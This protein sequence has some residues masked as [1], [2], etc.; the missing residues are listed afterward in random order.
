[1]TKLLTCFLFFIF[2]S[3]LLQASESASNFTIKNGFK[4]NDLV[5]FVKKYPE[6]K[7]LK[8]A[9]GINYEVPKNQDESY[10]EIKLFTEKSNEAYVVTKF[11]N[12]INIEKVNVDF[13]VEIKNYEGIIRNT[14]YDSV[15][16]EI[17][18]SAKS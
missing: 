1:M 4:Q 15:M 11:G 17:N 9:S 7:T 3:F 13:N 6:L 5:T 16:N 12:E 2:Y 10:L 8:L 18:F 14:L